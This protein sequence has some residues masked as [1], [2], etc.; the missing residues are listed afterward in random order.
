MYFAN[1]LF[2]MALR[3]SAGLWL[4][5]VVALMLGVIPAP[6]ALWRARGQRGQPLRR[7]ATAPTM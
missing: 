4:P 3:L 7:V 2:A 1:I 5:L 6:L